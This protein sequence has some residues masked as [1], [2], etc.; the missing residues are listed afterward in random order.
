MIFILTYHKVHDQRGDDRSDFYTI[1]TSQFSRHIEILQSLG[2]QCLKIEELLATG[3]IP[4]KRFILTFDDGTIDHYEKVAP[5]LKQHGCQ[6]VFFIPTSRLNLPGYITNAHVQEMAAAGHAIGFH[7][8]E[9]RRLDVLPRED[10]HRQISLSQKIIAD[11]IGAKPV[12]FVPPGGFLNARVREV[13]IELGVR[14]MRT[15]RYGFNV[16]PDLLAL[17]TVPLNCYMNDKKFEQLIRSPR[18]PWVYSSKE[19]L[20]RLIPMRGYEGLRTLLVKIA[21]PQ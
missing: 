20:K 14:L 1:S 11:I 7:S 3:Q 9:H 18:V 21:R 16:K 8:H 2:H 15:M 4:E 10:I 19:T 5:I 12:L 6:G 13:A 17:E